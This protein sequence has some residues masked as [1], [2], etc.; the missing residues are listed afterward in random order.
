[1]DSPV[2]AERV[3]EAARRLRPDLAV[4]ARARDNAHARR[5]IAHGASHV[6]PE[7]TEASLQL[8]EIVLEGA[9]VPES[10]ARHAVEA[11]RQAKQE[12][13]DESR[14]RKVG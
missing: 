10:A 3:V 2:P 7:L 1:M 12:A 6:V 13:V 5:L 11:R 14:R 4:Y 9:G 8:A